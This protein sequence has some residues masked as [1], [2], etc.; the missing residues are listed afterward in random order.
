MKANVDVYSNV[1]M[2]E[3]VENC[4]EF[5]STPPSTN[6]GPLGTIHKQHAQAN[7]NK[8]KPCIETHICCWHIIVVVFVVIIGIV[9]VVIV[10]VEI[11]SV[12]M[13]FGVCL[14]AFGVLLLL[15]TKEFWLPCCLS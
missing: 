15:I 10:V 6:V 1:S 5:T 8:S 13:V 2:L 11:D 14:I 12:A 7:K 3:G 9:V 4:F